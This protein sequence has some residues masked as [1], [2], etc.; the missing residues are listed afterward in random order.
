MEVRIFTLCDGA[1]NYKGKLTIVGTTDNIKVAKVPSN[2]DISLA[3]KLSFSSEEKGEKK[4]KLR[5]IKPD[6]SLL[7][8]ELPMGTNLK[9]LKKG[10]VGYLAFAGSFHSINIQNIGDYE[11][12]LIV[13]KSSFVLPFKVTI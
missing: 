13:N 3:V 6:G 7:M 2:I 9:E 5:F 1:F 11:I 12:E 8:P 10:E 4:I